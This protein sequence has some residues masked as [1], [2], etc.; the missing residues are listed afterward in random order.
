MRAPIRRVPDRDYEA[1]LVAARE[2]LVP[3]LG[4]YEA[5]FDAVSATRRIEDAVLRLPERSGIDL[6]QMDLAGGKG[7]GK[8]RLAPRRPPIHSL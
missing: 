7:G 6:G 8:R 2:K 5:G 1:A 3:V 4:G